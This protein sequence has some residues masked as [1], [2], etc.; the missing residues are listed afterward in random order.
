MSLRKY[1]GDVIPMKT[2]KRVLCLLLTAL[3]L[4]GV[5]PA[6]FALPETEITGKCGSYAGYTLDTETGELTIGII[7]GAKSAYMDNYENNESP[8]YGNTQ[9]KSVVITAWIWNVGSRAFAG[10]TNLEKIS[11]AFTVNQIGANALAGCDKAIVTYEGTEKKWKDIRIGEGNDWKNDPA[12]VVFA[13]QSMDR[14]S[15]VFPQ[16]KTGDKVKLNANLQVG[17]ADKYEAQLISVTY[18]KNGA[19]VYLKDGDTLNENAEYSFDIAF[20]ANDGYAMEDDTVFEI[21]G[22]PQDA[23]FGTVTLKL[24]P[25]AAETQQKESGTL[26]MLAYN[27]SGIPLIGDFQGSTFTTTNDRAKKLGKLLNGTD[28]D[29]ISVEEDFNGHEY[30]AAEMSNYPYRSYTSGGLAQGQ[31]LNVFSGH[32]LYNIDRVKWNFEYGTVSGS[33]DALSNKGFLYSLMEFAPG[34][35]INVITV[36]CDAGYEPLSV[37]ARST[38]FK[39]LAKYINENLNDGRALIV[40]GDF[41]FKFKRNLKDDLVK[42]LLAPTGLK[43]VWAEVYNNGITDPGYPDF[44]RDVDGDD[45]DRVL[46]RS[47][48][49]LTLEPVAKTVPELTGP[50][51]ERYTD[52]NPMLTEFTYTCSGKEDTPKDLTVPTPE[53]KALLT[54]KEALWTVVRILQAVIGVIELPYLIGQGVELLINGKMA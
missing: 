31:G 45:L 11:L 36:H 10:C 49:N 27:V 12:R 40:Q 17:D 9:I 53:N 50:N 41:N 7:G 39:Q 6:A 48:T 44:C 16:P 13:L 5:V 37:K 47:G 33:C 22:K 24:V 43:D 34:V 29:F 2:V 23:A 4:I 20:M 25:A 28:V 8:F 51:G 18:Q 14:V 35:Y 15:A 30:L 38:N 54:F 21:N 46:Y 32:K 3:L 19:T 52:H 1:K 42:N 26:K